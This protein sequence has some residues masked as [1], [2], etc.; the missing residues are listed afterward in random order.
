MLLPQDQI[1]LIHT[2]AMDLNLG[3]QRDALFAGLGGLLSA[4]AKTDRPAAQLLMD[5]YAL[6]ERPEAFVGEVAPLE[7]WL[8]NA[9]AL[10]PGDPRA[11]VFQNALQHLQR[12]RA[13]KA[14]PPTQ[15]ISHTARVLD[16]FEQWGA[17]CDQCDSNDQ[18]LVFI[19]HAEPQQHLHLF[20]QRIATFFNDKQR[21]CPR[22][23]TLVHLDRSEGYSTA[24][25]ALEWQRALIK[26][27][28][29][30]PKANG[31]SF[32]LDREV[33]QARSPVLYLLTHKNGPLQSF[34]Q[35]A[36][37]GL[38]AFFRDTIN[39][40]LASF[41]KHNALP[42]PLRFVIPIEHT[43]PQSRPQTEAL[44]NTLTR[45]S[46]LQ[47]HFIPE[48]KSPPWEEVEFYILRFLEDR[49]YPLDNKDRYETL[50]FECRKIF[51]E[52]SQSVLELGQALHH[53]LTE[54][55]EQGY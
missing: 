7:I 40:A 17:L 5:L 43:H 11:Q 31:L 30:G 55:D 39:S 49:G 48:L 2:T 47:T 52:H 18:H 16:R 28:S 32:V 41:G 23:H 53:Y 6:N 15:D 42:H 36:A 24:I 46:S 38:G 33:R 10:C 8:Q 19:V 50:L 9:L 27:S 12:A 1:I 29:V 34:D 25:S 44:A 22:H 45:A 20:V 35:A 21:G 4:L 26:T 13:S 54:W 14:Q 37:T 3:A 51:E